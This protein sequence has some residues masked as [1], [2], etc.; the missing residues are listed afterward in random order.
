MRS[1]NT[2]SPGG[3]G[4]PRTLT[5]ETDKVTLGEGSQDQ[6]R[7]RVNWGTKFHFNGVYNNSN[8]NNNWFCTTYDLNIS[9]QELAVLLKLATKDQLFQFNN[10]LYQQT[11]GVAMGF[12][13]G[14]LLANAFLCHIEE[15]LESRNLLPSY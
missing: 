11:D 12:P 1:P 9:R 10:E 8:N 15:T 4:G 7:E 3:M 14:P 2:D 6:A 13:L 5:L